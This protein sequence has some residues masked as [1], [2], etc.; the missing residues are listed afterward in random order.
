MSGSRGSGT[1]GGDP[2]GNPVLEGGGEALELDNRESV[3]RQHVADDFHGD[4]VVFAGPA[5]PH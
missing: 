3:Q 5:A 2:A 4:Q 1:G